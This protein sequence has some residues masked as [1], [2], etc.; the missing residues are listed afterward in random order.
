[1]LVTGG[2]ADWKNETFIHHASL[3]RAGIFTPEW[4][5]ALVK[6]ADAILFDRR[7]DPDQIHNLYDDPKHRSTV[8]ELTQRVIAHNREVEAPALEWLTG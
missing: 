8:D 2:S 3:E 5:F 7:N 6:G 1:M 4:E